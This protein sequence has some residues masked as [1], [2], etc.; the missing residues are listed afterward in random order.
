ME[1]RAVHQGPRVVLVRRDRHLGVLQA[2]LDVP[3]EV[4]QVG[5][6]GRRSG[7]QGLVLLL[8]GLQRFNGRGV[9]LMLQEVQSFAH[10]HLRRQLRRCVLQ[11]E[12]PQ[13]LDEIVVACLPVL[14]DHRRD[15]AGCG[16]H[17]LHVLASA[18][19]DLA[20]QVVVHAEQRVVLFRNLIQDFQVDIVVVPGA[21]ILLDGQQLVEVPLE[22]IPIP[23]GVVAQQQ[24]E[25]GLDVWALPFHDGL[26]G[27][28]GVL[29]L[30]DLDVG[31][32]DVADNLVLQVLARIRNLVQGEPVHLNR[33]GHLVLLVVDVPHV[34][35]QPAALGV[36]LVADDQAVGVQ[37]FGVQL[38]FLVLHRQVEVHGV[39]EVD[40]DLVPQPLLLAVLAQRA[41]LLAGLLGLLQGQGVVLLQ[42]ELRTLLDQRVD[43]A[44][45][46]QALLLG[47]VR[48]L[49]LQRGGRALCVA[50]LQGVELAGLGLIP[51]RAVGGHWPPR[52]R[53]RSLPYSRP[54]SGAPQALLRG[55][56]HALGR[57]GEGVAFPH[58]GGARRGRR[59]VHCGAEAVQ[60][61]VP[62]VISRVQ[63]HDGIHLR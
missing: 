41:L 19:A 7:L 44:L 8:K 28:D 56:P 22:L 30:S 16:Q 18:L 58:G 38:V 29:V 9:F 40:V 48:A 14:L 51:R 4:V 42:A 23:Q 34:H 26:V 1:V 39:G 24:V 37:S 31:I 21:A 3:L 57:G 20:A 10:L 13:L 36:L 49:L 60:V 12:V 45:H 6:V 63:A 62:R 32:A 43:P 15:Q 17:N 33:K 46:F 50:L 59:V 61:I 53:A 52:A 25:A 5:Q 35:P 54:W 11:L 27:P 2:V 47:A 55:G